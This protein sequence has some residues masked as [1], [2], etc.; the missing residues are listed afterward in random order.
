MGSALLDRHDH[1]RAAYDALAP[2]YDD[3]TADY[4]HEAWLSAIVA[5]AAAH[6]TGGRRMFDV[7][8]GTGKSFLPMLSRG[9]L[10]SASDISP[11]MVEEARRKLNGDGGR[12]FQAD[13]RDLPPCGPFDLVTC[14]D[15][16]VNYLLSGE[17]LRA[18]VSS[19]ASVLC[20][21]GLLVFDVNSLATYRTTFAEE[22]TLLRDGALFR[23]RGHASAETSPGEL[24]AATIDVISRGRRSS[25]RHLQRHH[26]RAEIEAACSAAGLELVAV[27]GQLPGGRLSRRADELRHTKVLYLTRRRG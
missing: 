1:A 20:P 8:C 18:A 6:G 7:A 13:M 21:G 16:A 27:R 4:D 22:F 24:C 26:P 5:L 15:D 23:W 25:S 2:F 19:M 11:S 10:V 17:D 9:W 12:V 3:L 14:L